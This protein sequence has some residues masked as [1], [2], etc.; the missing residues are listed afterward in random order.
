[1]SDMSGPRMVNGFEEDLLRVPDSL[2]E[3]TLHLPNHGTLTKCLVQVVFGL[4]GLSTEKTNLAILVRNTIIAFHSSGC[5]F[6]HI[7][8]WSRC[9]Y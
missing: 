6:F 5:R 7:I 3:S 4:T 9:C 2:I 8:V 1:M